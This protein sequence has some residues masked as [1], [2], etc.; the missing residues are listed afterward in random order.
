MAKKSAEN[1]NKT[2]RTVVIKTPIEGPTRSYSVGQE[3]ELPLNEAERLIE[4]GAATEKA[5]KDE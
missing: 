3:V 2:T 1:E 4:S 5:D